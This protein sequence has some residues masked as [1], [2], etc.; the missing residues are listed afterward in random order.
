MESRSVE[1]CY[2][3]ETYQDSSGKILLSKVLQSLICGSGNW[4]N[5]DAFT[6]GGGAIHDDLRLS[7][8]VEGF[9]QQGGRI[10]DSISVRKCQ[11]YHHLNGQVVYARAFAD[12]E[13]D[14]CRAYG[15]LHECNIAR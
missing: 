14:F 8:L 3:Q 11:Y 2:P 13:L 5:C 6:V 12:I 15:R 10:E 4:R 7:K 9:T 1:V